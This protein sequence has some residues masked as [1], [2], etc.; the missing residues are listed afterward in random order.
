MYFLSKDNIKKDTS[1][2]A[3]PRVL[4]RNTFAKQ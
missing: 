4:W 3:K 1:V 2:A